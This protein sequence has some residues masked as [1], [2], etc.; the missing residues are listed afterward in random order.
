MGEAFNA[1]WAEGTQ[2]PHGLGA[3]RPGTYARVSRDTAEA[4]TESRTR[5]QPIA[6]GEHTGA[7]R[8]WR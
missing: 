4:E 1:D 5:P 6:A 3:A 7:V 2:G 8:F